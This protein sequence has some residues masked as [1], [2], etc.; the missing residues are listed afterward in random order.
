MSK[1]DARL[2]MRIHECKPGLHNFSE[3]MNKEC[4]NTAGS[5]ECVCTD[6]YQLSTN[7]GNATCERISASSTDSVDPSVIAGIAISILVVV[8]LICLLLVFLLR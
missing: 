1:T 6:G 5:F 7:S 3:E 8:G 2:R 4:N